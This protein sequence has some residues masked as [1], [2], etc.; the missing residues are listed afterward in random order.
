[1]AEKS[2]TVNGQ[3]EIKIDKK[4]REYLSVPYGDNKRQAIYG[5]TELWE[6]VQNGAILKLTGVVSGNFFNVDSFNLDLPDAQPRKPMPMPIQVAKV[7]IGR[8][9]SIETQVAFKGGIELAVAYITSGKPIPQDEK[10]ATNLIRRAIDWGRSR[11]P[12]TTEKITK[13]IAEK[14]NEE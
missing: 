3:P 9:E 4:G 12:E 8:E 1:M 5:N 7:P 14:V 13:A 2:L 11:L 10:Q 6:V